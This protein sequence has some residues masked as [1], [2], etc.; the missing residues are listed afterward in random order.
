MKIGIKDLF[1]KEE[2]TEISCGY[3]TV[4]PHCGLQGGRTEGFILFPETNTAYCHSSGKWFTLLQTVALKLK[5]I[6]CIE[7]ND[8][9]ESPDI[10][11]EFKEEIYEQI[12]QEYGESFLKEFK[13]ID[14]NMFDF[15]IAVINGN[16]IKYI[17][18]IN[19]VANHIIET[20]NIKTVSGMKY[21][22]V[23]V[24]QE[25]VWNI[26]GEGLI[27]KD[28]EKLLDTYCNNNNISEISKKIQRKTMINKEEFDKVP[29][30]KRCVM[31]GVID[32]ENVDDIKF[33]PHSKEYNFKTKLPIYYDNKANCPKINKFIEDTFYPDDIQQMKEWFGHHLPKL[34]L[35]KKAVLIHG[36]KHTGKTVF[37]NL[38]KNFIGR[39]NTIGLS[40]QEISN[41]NSFDLHFL[42]DKIGNIHD[43]LSS[44]DL[45]DGGGFKMAVGDG[46]IS[47]EQKFGDRHIFRNSAK[48][49]FTCN[50]IPPVKD[51]DDDAY[52]DR[53]LL[54]KLDNV[55]DRKNKNTKLIS[56][57]T[58]KEEL[59]GLLNHAIKGYVNLIKRN[60]FYKEKEC[61]EIKK[62]M[63]KSGNSYSKFATDM[64]REEIGSKITKEEMYNQYCHYC[65][66]QIPKISPQT[67]DNLGKQLSRFAPYLIS[68]SNGKER[69]WL[70]V[71]INLCVNMTAMTPFQKIY[72]KTKRDIN[73]VEILDIKIPKVSLMSVDKTQKKKV[74]KVSKKS[75][76]KKKKTDREIQFDDPNCP[77]TKDMKV[78]CSKE[79]TLEWIKNNP[80]KN[81][82]EM[83]KELGDGCFKFR[84][85]LKIEEKIK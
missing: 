54:W 40:L 25:G 5:I 69:Y 9:G 80:N 55:V 76:T 63:I 66:S 46:D 26:L 36:P 49:T 81:S 2:L 38:L 85:E 32:F 67:K 23:Y 52:Y 50:T 53:W 60:Y 39:T 7:G 11:E 45:N 34:Y 74:K 1:K 75:V 27:K 16:K 15:L 68:S 77:D 70:N 4:C 72:I 43:D 42:K 3:K 41:G 65:V 37:I 44:K 31:N 19:K 10:T 57:L 12:K 62:L 58:T 28:I 18:N 21:D 51:I 64:L 84:N 83:Y 29:E 47:G 14:Q 6:Q 17:V 33:L 22:I 35:F 78:K 30:Y 24:Y 71:K 8:S 79:Q 82:K 20:L 61:D 56:E 73:S 48:M 13:I 59:S